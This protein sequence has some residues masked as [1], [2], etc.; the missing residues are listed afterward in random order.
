MLDHRPV[1]RTRRSSPLRRWLVIVGP[2]YV[3]ALIA[4]ALAD[5]QLAS[6]M[7]AMLVGMLELN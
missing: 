4:A 5:P 2:A 7:Q 1:N 6:G 3:V